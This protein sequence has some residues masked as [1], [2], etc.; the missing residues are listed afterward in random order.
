MDE[1]GSEGVLEIVS[2]GTNPGDGWGRGDISEQRS[3]GVQITIKA[4]RLSAT[5]G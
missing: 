1:N 3:H 2:P 4:S 5:G